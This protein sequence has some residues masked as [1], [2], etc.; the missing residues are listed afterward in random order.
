MAEIPIFTSS[1]D[2]PT[3]ASVASKITDYGHEPLLFL[4]DKVAKGEIEFSFSV[5]D[6]GES[7]ISYNSE[8][9]D[10]AT[11][12]SA[13]FRHPGV[14]N[15]DI[16]DNAKRFCVENEVEALFE[17]LWQQ[18]P[19]NAWLNHP[20]RMRNVQAKIAQLVTAGEVG[21]RI[22]NTVVSNDW[23]NIESHLGDS[24]LVAKMSKGLLYEKDLT[25]VLY[26]TVV[27]KVMRSE[28]ANNNPFPA[29][30]QSFKSKF[31]E[32][33]I[34]VVGDDVFEAAIYTSDNAKDDWRRH[35]FTDNVQFVK[36][37]MPNDIIDKSLKFL[38]KVGLTYGAFDF[39]ENSDGEITFLECNTNGQ[40]KWLEILL[41]FPIS[42]AVASQLLRKVN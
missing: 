15:L 41:G 14:L 24:L 33:R 25:K 6:E 19:E 7:L 29:I 21:F 13:W 34:T 26:T 3:Y 2:E 22:P 28:L 17:S 39:I 10:P 23:N 42:D 20:D 4:S 16:S 40:Y 8:I 27:D 12:Q 18:V 31:R 36:E 11:I 32:W 9:I 1:I 35:Q 5:T 37:K 30:Y 38:G